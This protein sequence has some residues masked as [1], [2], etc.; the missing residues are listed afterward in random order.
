MASLATPFSKI[1]GTCTN[2]LATK[3]LL[4]KIVELEKISGVHED[5][6]R[7]AS[8]VDSVFEEHLLN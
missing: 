8:I 6:E 2:H 1:V 5:M 7:L 3:Q 4:F